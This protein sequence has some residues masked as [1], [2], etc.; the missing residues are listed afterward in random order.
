MKNTPNDLSRYC[1]TCQQ[2]MRAGEQTGE[3]PL[4]IPFFREGSFQQYHCQECDTDIQIATSG[5]VTVQFGSVMMALFLSGLIVWNIQL[6][7]VWFDFS[8]TPLIGLLSGVTALIAAMFIL[9]GI[10]NGIG[11]IRNLTMMG[12]A[13]LCHRTAWQIL[14]LIVASILYSFIPWVYWFGAGFLNDTVFHIDRDWAVAL[15]VPGLLPFFVAD[16]VGLSPTTIFF[17]SASYP[18]AGFIYMWMS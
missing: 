12:K 10:Y 4:I 5:L 11:L 1:P 16:R 18:T 14:I 9:D 7:P 8:E 3:A 6:L 13:P 2:P 17:L 15:V